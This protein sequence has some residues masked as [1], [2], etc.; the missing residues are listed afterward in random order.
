M[1]IGR[2]LGIVAANVKAMPFTGDETAIDQKRIIES[3]A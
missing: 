1:R 3:G 2:L